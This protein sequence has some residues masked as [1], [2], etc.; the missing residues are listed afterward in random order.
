MKFSQNLSFGSRDRA[1]TTSFFGPN[2]ILQSAGVA[3]N[4]IFSRQLLNKWPIRSFCHTFINSY[5]NLL[6]NFK[7]CP[8]FFL[9]KKVNYKPS[10]NFKES[11]TTYLLEVLVGTIVRNE[12]IGRNK[13]LVLTALIP[14]SC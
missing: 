7:K 9:K 10:Y 12:A 8:L 6:D 4:M 5:S 3:L 1:Q 11:T 2:L 14:E 13:Q